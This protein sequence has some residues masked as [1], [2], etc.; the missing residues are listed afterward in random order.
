[1][2]YQINMTRWQTGYFPTTLSRGGILSFV[3]SNGADR[4]TCKI[5]LASCFFLTVHDSAPQCS[6]LL[7]GADG[8][9]KA[10]S[11]GNHPTHEAIGTWHQQNVKCQLTRK[12]KQG[13]CLYSS[14]SC[15]NQQ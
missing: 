1:M 13:L 9:Q 8:L 2:A 15:G 12:E 5:F 6:T 10:S 14:C 11:L 7:S 4:S 3:E